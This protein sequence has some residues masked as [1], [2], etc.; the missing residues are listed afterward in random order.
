[1]QVNANAPSGEVDILVVIVEGQWTFVVE[2]R[3]NCCSSVTVMIHVTLLEH[4]SMVYTYLALLPCSHS[5]AAS[6]ATAAGLLLPVACASS[7]VTD[8]SSY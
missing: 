8:G 7:T 5:N 2:Y 4:S 1:M 3:D 6:S